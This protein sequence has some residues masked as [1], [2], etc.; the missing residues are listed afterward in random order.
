VIAVLGVFGREILAVFGATYT[1]GYVPL[2]VY[3]GGI[4]VG[5]AVGAT[6]WLLL[7]TEHQYA[8]MLLDW[9]LAGLNVTLTYVFI[10]RFGLVGAALGT[11][12]AISVQ[13]GIQVV[14]LRR[15]EGLWPFDR[16]FIRPIL[17]GSIASGLMATVRIPLDGGFAVVSGTLLGVIAYIGILW[18]IGIDARDQLIVTE[19]YHRYRTHLFS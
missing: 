4:L 1:Q 8:R 3:L 12:L 15:F 13:N 5:S 19:L 11:S 10:T 14:L 9:L 7:M 6:G 2:V 17:A 16:T 18:L